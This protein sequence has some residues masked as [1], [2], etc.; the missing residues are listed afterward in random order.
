MIPFSESLPRFGGGKGWVIMKR[1]VK[2]FRKPHDL[3]GYFAKVLS[4]RINRAAKKEEPIN[5]ALSGGSTPKILFSILAEKY[6]RSTS[7]NYV[8]IFWVD[9]RCVPPDDP[10]SN[11][12]MTEKILLSKI[13]IP[14]GNVFRIIGEDDPSKEALRYSAVIERY[15]RSKKNIPV[16]DIVILGMGDDGHTASIFPGDKRL[17][18]SEKICETVVHPFSNQKRVTV[19]VKVINNSKEIYFLVTGIK[20]SEIVNEIFR[21]SSVSGMFPAAH[22]KSINGTTTWLLD[23]EAAKFIL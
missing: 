23:N 9:E 11:F 22:I 19:T 6:G 7:W 13:E 14:S 17:L 4:T 21:N 10:E 18:A 5:I 3:A 16:F 15:T 1:K 20:K 2:I 8:H 12:G